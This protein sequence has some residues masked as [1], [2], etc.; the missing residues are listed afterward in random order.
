MFLRP[1][2]RLRPTVAA[3]AA[4]IVLAMAASAAL[5]APIAIDSPAQ[6]LAE[7]IK[8]LAKAAG[9]TIA[10]DSA[11]L[12]G[13]TAPAVKGSMEPQEALRRLLA[14][15]GLVG[16]VDD[17]GSVVLKPAPPPAA[18]SDKSLPAVTVTESA[19]VP[20]G[21]PKPYSG[22]Q[23]AKGARVGILGNL[24]TFSTPFSITAYTDT[25]LRDQQ[26]RSIADVVINDPSI[27]LGLPRSGLQDQFVV[28][29]FRTFQQDILFDGVGGVVD[30]RRPALDNIE[31]VE[32]LKG[33]S[34]LLYNTTVNGNFSGVINYVP[35]RAP[36]ED[37]NRISVGFVSREE[38][39]TSVDLGRRF[40]PDNQW[41]V[42]LNATLRD[43]DGPIRGSETEYQFGSLGLDYRGERL[44]ASFDAG[45]QAQ[46]HDS[47][48]ALATVGPLVTVMPRVPKSNINQNPPWTFEHTQLKFA[49]GRVEFDAT[50][51]LTVYAA[52]GGSQFE[53]NRFTAGYTIANNAGDRTGGISND[54]FD[55]ISYG[56]DVGLKAKL[57]TGPINHR[58]TVSAAGNTRAGDYLNT[59]IVAPG[60][61]TNI[62]NPVF[63]A[64]PARRE[65]SKSQY[66]PAGRTDANSVAISN[67]MTAYDERIVVALGGRSQSIETKNYQQTFGAANFGQLTDR[68][69]DRAF[70][71]ALGIVV[72][73]LDRLSLYANYVEGLQAGAVAP[74]EA[75]NA[76]QGTPPF[77]NKQ[78]EVGAK[79][80][81]GSAGVTVSY[82]EIER[83]SAFTDPTTLVFAVNGRQIN[84]GF[85]L[86]MFG[87][88]LRGLRLLGGVAFIDANLTKTAGGTLDGRTSPGV[89]SHQGVVYAEYDL[90]PGMAP[91]LTLTGRV[92]YS[93]S[94]FV[95][96]TN[97]LTIPSWTRL[98]AGLRYAFKGFGGKP[99]VLR[100][101]VE[102]LQD[103]D[104]F[105]TA[106]DGLVSQ[107][108]P[109]T[110]K[111]SAQFDF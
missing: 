3:T 75:V 97:T 1:A 104:Y 32:I 46:D 49:A 77:K 43:G 2:T 13:K 70:S 54:L 68:Y 14:G 108:A 37:L 31:R 102:N 48:Q 76:G 29:G 91:G 72:K 64:A 99:A 26:A 101:E 12:T 15:S 73:P 83:Q 106:I 87:E 42:R 55:T 107:S 57:K 80:D 39:G 58:L 85:E 59:G 53:S 94:Q 67:V 79:Y 24:D 52:G 110:F 25:L 9:L 27:Q 30:T 38:I 78:V 7:A 84:K 10:A 50:D 6:P 8:A 20:G 56:Y 81:F 109:R 34:A 65:F 98:D 60:L 40:G 5:A 11:L 33:P 45:Y 93:G 44:R 96:R 71:P 74:V 100:F 66:A 90:P 19:E 28:R 86:N 103:K 18:E 23:V 35:K 62:Y 61:A 82:F 105:Q 36:D 69:S 22:G 16:T 89:P 47:F 95:N 111:L 4:A 17:R 63:P 88:P 92:L 41:G 51:W 21:L